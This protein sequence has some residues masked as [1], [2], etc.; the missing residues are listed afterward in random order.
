MMVAWLFSQPD[1]QRIN[2]LASA[3]QAVYV[4][5]SRY[6]ILVGRLRIAM[7]V[8]LIFLQPD[9]QLNQPISLGH[10]GSLFL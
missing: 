7:M 10:L 6:L 9:Y 8:A 5:N 3:S 4:Y 2:Q 1:I